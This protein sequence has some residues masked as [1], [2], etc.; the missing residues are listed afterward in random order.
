M[1]R[2]LKLSIPTLFIGFTISGCLKDKNYNNG[3]IQSV[4]NN[5]RTNERIIEVQL[6]ATGISNFLFTSFDASNNDTT[7]NLVPIVLAGKD[8][9]SEDINVTL[10]SKPQLIDDYNNANSTAYTIPA[11]AMYTV[12]NQ[13]NVVTIPKGS[14]VGYLKIKFKTS[15]FVGQDWAFGYTISSIDK[16]GYTISGNLK[17]GIFAFG[18][19]NKYDGHYTMTGTM[20]DAAVPSITGQFPIGVNLETNGGSSVILNATEGPFAGAYFFPILNNGSA[21]AYGS[22]TPVFILDAN[23]NVVDVVNAYGQPAGNTRSAQLDPSG[24]NKWFATDKHMDVKFWMNQP[25]VIA[26][27]RTSFDLH[28][29]YVAPR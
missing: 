26:G 16:P 1:N 14:R 29:T 10:T 5:G 27:H 23:D 6:T 28:F 15:D 9:A 21:S 18:I 3:S 20:V 11:A 22:F 17:E 25:S 8:V 4:H 2:F 13:N 7:I 12:I 24:T 19:K